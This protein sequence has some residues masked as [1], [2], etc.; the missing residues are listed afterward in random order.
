[1][2]LRQARRR[3]GN[4]G[5]CARGRLGN[6]A[7][8]PDAVDLQTAPAGLRQAMVYYPLST[9]MLAGI[10]DIL[11]I[12]T[13]EDQSSFQRLLGSGERWGSDF[14]TSS[15]RVRKDWRRRTSSARNSWP[16]NR[17]RSFWATTSFSAMACRK[18]FSRAAARTTGATVFGYRVRDPERYGVVEFDDAGRATSI[19][20]KAVEAEIQLCRNG[21]LFL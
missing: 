18:P 15:S 8:S 1:M 12:T 19:E 4:E 11:I 5:N 10:R 3:A 2:N 17:A 6:A 9:L 16:A 20:E 14:P 21:P 7:L 13:P